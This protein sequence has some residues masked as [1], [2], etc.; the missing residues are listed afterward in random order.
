[1]QVWPTGITDEYDTA[2]NDRVEC[3]TDEKRV[4]CK[5]CRTQKKPAP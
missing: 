2:T 1:V 5:N 4:T 3:V